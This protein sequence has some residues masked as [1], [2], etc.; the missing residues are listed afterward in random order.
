MRTTS[1]VT[2]GMLSAIVVF[3]AYALAAPALAATF[4]VTKIADTNDGTCGLDCSLREAIGAANTLAGADIINLPAGIYTLS[5]AGVGEDA[6]ATGDLDITGDLTINGAGNTS[7]IIDGGAIDRVITVL[8]GATVFIDAVTIRNGDPGPGFG[9]AGILNAGTLTLTNSAVTDNTG[10]DF[11]GGIYNTGTLTLTDSTVSDN[12]LLGSNASGGGGGIFSQGTSTLTRTT[13]SGNSTIGRGGGIYNLDLTATIT[14]STV[15]GNTALNGG[16]IFNRFGTVHLVSSTISGNIA[17]DNGGGIWNLGGT[18]SLK[19]TIVSGNT[20]ATPSDD[21]AG[22]ITSLG[23]NL[24]GDASC[25]LLGAGD[26]NSTDPLLGP[27]ADNGGPTMTHALLLGSPAIDAVPLASCTVVTDQRGVPRPKGVACDIGAFEVTVC[28]LPVFGSVTITICNSGVIINSTTANSSTGGNTAE[29]SRGGR[30]GRGG[31]VEAE[32]DGYD[33]EANG[34]NGGALAGDGGNGGNASRGGIVITG[35]AISTANTLNSLNGTEIELAGT[36]L[37]SSAIE[38]G[39]DNDNCKCNLV[40]N[41]TRARA[42]TGGNDAKGSEGGD[43]GPGGEIEAEAED[44]DAEANGNNGGAVG[45]NGGSGG[46][47]GLGGFIGTG[48]ADSTATTTNKLNFT[49]IKLFW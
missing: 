47:G 31:D 41:K 40:D 13:V 49:K 18:I 37:N 5:I 25:A 34:N 28:D 35:T 23:H 2:R 4:D 32:A 17:T 21:C 46:S 9:A 15:S 14:N 48:F 27:L 1:A 44:G 30:G 29:G 7:S 26:L 45:G 22:T 6:N 16:G 19:N 11:G 20:A 12:T 33:A 38:V 8:S 24:A 10:D 43:G 36:D 39:I 42:R 3:L